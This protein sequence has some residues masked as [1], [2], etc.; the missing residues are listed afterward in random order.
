[1]ALCDWCKRRRGCEPYK[2][3]KK[4]GAVKNILTC[5]DYEKEGE[6]KGDKK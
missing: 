2:F 3:Q 4:Q 1:M 5:P 6:N